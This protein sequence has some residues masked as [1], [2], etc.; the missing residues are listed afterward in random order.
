MENLKANFIYIYT[1]KLRLK[2][3]DVHKSDPSLELLTYDTY[4]S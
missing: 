3:D 4:K 1:K 2:E